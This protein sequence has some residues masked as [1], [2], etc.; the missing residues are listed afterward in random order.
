MARY[1]YRGVFVLDRQIVYAGAIALDTDQL[2]QS[3]N[4]MIALGYLTK[5]VIGDSGSF[6]DGLSCTPGQGMSIVVG[7]GSL[8]SPSVVD[9]GFVGALPPDGDPLVKIGINTSPLVLPVS[10]SGVFMISGSLL[11]IQA[12]NAVVAYYNAADPAQTLFGP[13]GDG[14]AQASVLQQRVSIVVTP[15]AVAPSGNVPLWTLTVPDGAGAITTGMIGAAPGAPF[16]T[17]KL[18]AAAPLLSPMFTGTPGAPTPAV[19]DSSSLL[20]TTAFV[21]A[22]NKRFRAIW[23]SHGSASWKCPAGVSQ[24]LFRGWGAGGAGGV[25]SGGYAGGGGGGGGYL[26]VLLDVV[27]GQSYAVLVGAG[28]TNAASVTATGFGG[29]VSVFGGGNG[30][31]GGSGQSGVGG[32]AGSDAVLQLAALSNPGAGVG[33]PG[34]VLAGASIGGAGGGCFGTATGYPTTNGGAGA[35]GFWPGGGGSGAASGA[36]GTGADGLVILEWSGNAAA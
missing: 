25:G 16:V 10:G 17:L 9:A 32:T 5:M 33:Q 29:I 1:P 18:P 22:A 11:E 24:V 2:L 35:A 7:P 21:G 12:G 19:G 31:N 4:A 27:A 30:G 28:G 34:Y 6:A 3:R 26:E 8:T 23:S 13:S 20:A 14:V 36:G 15:G